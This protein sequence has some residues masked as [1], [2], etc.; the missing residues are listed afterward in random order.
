MRVSRPPC[1][2][3]KALHG[4]GVLRRC[5]TD[6]HPYSL[7]QSRH[8]H[9]SRLGNLTTR[10]TFPALR[11]YGGMEVARSGQTPMVRRVR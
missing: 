2:L 3:A 1:V 5:D 4:I 8:L 6:I 10:A 11:G 9:R 7:P